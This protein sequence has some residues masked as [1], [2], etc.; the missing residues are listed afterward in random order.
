MLI[1]LIGPVEVNTGK[2]THRLGAPKLACALATLAATPGRPVDLPTL[3]TH[4]WGDD[5][6]ESAISVLYSYMTRLRAVFR[7]TDQATLGRAGKHGYLLDTALENIDVHAVRELTHRADTHARNGDHHSALPLWRSASELASGE[8]LV[9]VGG[10][11]A[12][13]YRLSFH[14]ERLHL[15]AGRFDSELELGYHSA[16][17]DEIAAAVTREPLS[18]PL[19]KHLMVA[20]YRCGRTVEA[21]DRYEATRIAMRE[22]LGSD[23]SPDLRRLHTRIL[24]QDASLTMTSNATGVRAPTA[25]A[26]SPVPAQLPPR[27]AGFVGRQ[28]EISRIR[29]HV[30]NHRPVVI[31][32]MAG[33]G[34]TALAVHVAHQLAAEYPDG[35]L[36]ADLSGFS[37]GVEPAKPGDVLANL[38][39]AF[40]VEVPD[41]EVER[42]AAFRTALAGRRVLLVLD[43][44]RDVSQI[45]PLLPGSGECAVIITSRQRLIDLVDARPVSLDSLTA[46]E[47]VELFTA[48]A[49]VSITD[50]DVTVVDE[51]AEFCGRLPL[52]LRIAASRLRHRPSW[53]V[54]DLYRRLV[55]TQSRLAALGTAD[56]GGVTATFDLS[57]F[58]LSPHDRRLFR[59]LSVTPAASFDKRVAATLSD[60]TVPEAEDAL[61]RLVDAHLVVPDEQG[62][63]R[64]HDLLRDY[65]AVHVDEQE[66][67]RAWHRLVVYYV[68]WSRVASRLIHHDFD[69][70]VTTGDPAKGPTDAAEARQWFQ[71]ELHTVV[72]MVSHEV[73]RANHATVADLCAPAVTYL[74]HAA[75]PSLHRQLAEYGAHACVALADVNRTAKFE[76]HIGLAYQELGLLDRSLKH[77]TKAL[78]AELHPTPP[79][80]IDHSAVGYLIINIATIHWHRGD[81]RQAVDQYKSAA[82]AGAAAEAARVEAMALC[83][84]ADPLTALGRFDEAR[85]ALD[86]AEDL[87]RQEGNR[88]ELTRALFNRALIS[89]AEGRHGTARDQF[90]EVLAF[91][92]DHTET[93]GELS[94]LCGL[95]DVAV[96]TGDYEEARELTQQVLSVSTTADI[97]LLEVDALTLLGRAQTGLGKFDD[98]AETLEAAITLGTRTELSRLRANAEFALGEL[99]AERNDVPGA[100]R[101]LTRA[102]EFFGNGGYPVAETV[103]RRMTELST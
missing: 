84:S 71:R 7:E 17:V 24:R 47:A 72:H 45:E 55:D 35:Q 4:V 37:A 18:E 97:P 80:D 6:P 59:L 62:L 27:T 79:T 41:D 42:S 89:H 61:E 57:Y 88:V 95:A 30:G 31:D 43:N 90:T 19:V 16:V 51:I 76:N 13:H 60:T 48:D 3:L 9:G 14:R 70:S 20:L 15:L 32:G 28:G 66:R 46:Q 40:D 38:L 63:Y 77:L 53:R 36:Y 82:E 8:A 50:G 1:R 83:N 33:V 91:C 99:L 103:R 67:S 58:Y 94:A 52:A 56:R 54:G 69:P 5:P 23:P 10:D 64:L 85:Q 102:A 98:A 92:R 68:S 22:R 73:A 44:A 100:L 21:L 93:V 49:D 101:L 39:R 12:A 34:K 78:S 74:L 75:S 25:T 2:R 65:A 96:S 26:P 86:R 11:W 87:S 81:A 29:N